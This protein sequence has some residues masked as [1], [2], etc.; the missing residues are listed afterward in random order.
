[1]PKISELAVAQIL[2]ISN[3]DLLVIVDKQTSTTK[4][5]AIKDF[6]YVIAEILNIDIEKDAGVDNPIANPDI[7]DRT[8]GDTV[9][10]SSPG[11]MNIDKYT[12]SP[13]EISLTFT[14]QAFSLSKSF[15]I[16]AESD[17]YTDGSP[18]T[19][20]EFL[21][22]AKGVSG[23][24]TIE[25]CKPVGFNRVLVYVESPSASTYEYTLTCTDTACTIDPTSIAASPTPT[26]TPAPTPTV[27][28]TARDA[29]YIAATPTATT[30]PTPTVTPTVT[31]TPTISITPSVTP[32]ISIT[33]SI[34]SSPT[35]TKT[36]TPTPSPS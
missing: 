3:D 28:P 10:P 29:G 34:T 23:G 5:I 25:I 16:V 30:T 2:D 20:R 36:P 18:A 27:T 24:E 35:P 17:S 32:T 15:S 11:V 19:H 26:S 14:Y 12:V 6:A 7:V 31:V 33:P 9:S 13:D 1:M 22:S 4:K 8:C 21:Y